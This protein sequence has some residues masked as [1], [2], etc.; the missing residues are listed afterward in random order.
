MYHEKLY[1]HFRNPRNAG[2]AAPPALTVDVE[3]PACGDWLRLGAWAD[4]GRVLEVK[5]KVRGCTA[6][7]AAGSALTEWMLGTPLADWPEAGEI[8]ASIEERLGGLPA[9]SRHAA[10]LAAEGALRW[11]KQFESGSAKA[12][13]RR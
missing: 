4:A 9:A 6:S 5:F 11:R 7:I 3:N 13:I 2:E 12:E 8:A 10:A 1:D